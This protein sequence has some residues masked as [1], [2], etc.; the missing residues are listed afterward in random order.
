MSKAKFT[1]GDKVY[2]AN[3]TAIWTVKSIEE[4]VGTYLYGFNGS[5]QHEFEGWLCEVNREN[6]D[7]LS[8]LYPYFTFEKPSEEN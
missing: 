2:R 6:C 8:K 3:S 1:I 7:S 5:E 4:V